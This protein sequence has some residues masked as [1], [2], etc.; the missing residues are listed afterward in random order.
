MQRAGREGAEEH[1]EHDRSI[2]YVWLLFGFLDHNLIDDC[3]LED[4][5][6]GVDGCP[7]SHDCCLLTLCTLIR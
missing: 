5:R 3:G 2:M 7:A 6:V 1:V 4:V